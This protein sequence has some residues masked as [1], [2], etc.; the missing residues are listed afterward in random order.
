MKVVLKKIRENAI[1]P[2]K[3]TEMSGAWDLY[4]ADLTTE[5]DLESNDSQFPSSV[6]VYTGFAMQCPPGYRIRIVPRSSLTNTKWI[7]QNSPAIGDADYTG[8]Y[9]IKFRSIDGSSPFPY[10]IGDRVAQMYIDEIIPIEFEY[11][12]ELVNFTDRVGG[13][14]STGK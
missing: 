6:T 14:G 10:G 7:M 5:P 11:V 13:F 9:L 12:D 2:Y 3:A 1:H 8:E 4:A